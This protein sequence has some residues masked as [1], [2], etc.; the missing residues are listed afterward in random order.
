MY[1][2]T[3]S[4]RTGGLVLNS[5][6]AVFSKEPRPVYAPELNLLGF[7][8]YWKYDQQTD[9]PCMWAEANRYYYRG[10]L[11]ASLLGGDVYHAPVVQLAYTCPDWRETPN[12]KATSKT[13]CENPEDKGESFTDKKGNLF[14]LDLPEPGGKL[15]PVD[16]TAMIDDNREILGWLEETTAKKIL[17]VYEKYAGKLDIFHVAF[18]GGKDSCVLLDLVKS[19]LPQD[20][21]VVV[22]GDTGMEFPDT[23]AVI[24][25]VEAQCKKDSVKFYRAS[26]HFSPAESWDLFAPPSRVLRWC[27]SVH[28]STPQT[29]ILREVTGKQNYVGLD[30]VGVRA[31]ESIARSEYE[32]ENYGKKQKGQYSHNSILEWTSA[33]VWLYI[34]A[35][36]LIINEAYKKGNGR[37]GCLFCPMSGGI[38]DYI[39][40][41]N[42]KV[43]VDQYI[44]IICRMNN[45]DL[46]KKNL[47]TYVTN[48]GWD[49]RRS[50]RGITGNTLRYSETCK[51]GTI[52]I[53]ITNP[54]SDWREWIKTIDDSK[55]RYKV[56]EVK[57]GYKIAISEA[58]M[59]ASPAYGKLFRQVFRKAA[60]CI[61]CKVCETNCKNGCI[62]FENGK[63]NI[64]DCIQCHNCIH[65]KNIN[66]CK[67][68]KTNICENFEFDGIHDCHQINSGC[69][70]Y[71]SRKI[72]QEEK[73]MKTI[74]C[75]DDHAPMTSWLAS[76]FKDKD[77]FFVS[78]DLGPNQVKCFRRF[79]KDAGLQD[80]NHCLPLAELLSEIGWDSDTSMGIIFTNLV[81]ENP[82]IDWYVA[83]LDIGRLYERKT[84]EDMLLALDMKEKAARS[85][86]KAYKRLTET[87]LGTKLN[88][89]YVSDDGDLARTVCSLSD[90]RVIL[91]ALY[92]FAEKCN[93]YKE[94]TLNALLSDN[95][96]RDGVSPT[97]IFGLDREAM[98]PL[99][100]GLSGKYPEFINATFTNDLDKI[101]LK[102]DKTSEDVLELF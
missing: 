1:S 4:A 23:Y 27:C 22:F 41:Q 5:T 2:Y 52:T 24:D 60:Y 48:G 51:N 87:P 8:K 57:D 93:D 63:I 7:D 38:S 50:G 82:Q 80:K 31:Q 68:E 91:Y 30:Y 29:L 15:R 58:E 101:S 73:T 19:V 102:D 53:T 77:D 67:R 40:R 83:N 96:E 32:Y 26:S 49:N 21:F 75:F 9:A 99:L 94:F 71:E 97:R 43:E 72:P 98:I 95:I 54:A 12:G 78:N 70:M 47:E 100:L 65:C 44:D 76:F 39:R 3:Y 33:E 14:A 18:S 17:D 64:K 62:T 34:Y 55:I 13:V 20:S 42:Y 74:N 61:G 89:G 25:K 36:D 28:K 45:W 92:K 59:K 84:V 11:V 46:G 79:L 35:H 86:A 85:V 69:L 88:F 66:K 81:Y 37:A 6:P 56:T 16:I 90:P 10:R